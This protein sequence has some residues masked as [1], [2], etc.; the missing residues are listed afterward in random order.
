MLAAD[1]L[2]PIIVPVCRAVLMTFPHPSLTPWIVFLTLNTACHAAVL[3]M[4]TILEHP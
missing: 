4:I 3:R 2:R 1:Q